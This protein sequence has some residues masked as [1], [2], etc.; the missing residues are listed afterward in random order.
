MFTSPNGERI[1]IMGNV[2]GSLD[3]Q[4]SFSEFVDHSQNCIVQQKVLP[5]SKPH[6]AAFLD[7]NGDC[8]SDLFFTSVDGSNKFHE[9][10]LRTEST[11]SKH[12]MY[13]LKFLKG[14]EK[15]SSQVTFTDF[16]RDGRVDF[17][18]SENGKVLVQRNQLPIPEVGGEDCIKPSIEQENTMF[19]VQQ[20]AL[21]SE[22]GMSLPTG[23]ASLYSSEGL[24]ATIR[25][26]DYNMDGYPDFLITWKNSSS[27]TP[28]AFLCESDGRILDNLAACNIISENV[29]LSTFFDLDEDGYF[30]YHCFDFI[31]S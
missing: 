13:C 24:P 31:K 2:N 8:L 9:I 6:S 4:V 19:Y 3:K 20:G 7:L 28:Q 14:V 11:T 5:F 23:V 30:N 1:V 15:D 18:Y 27:G 21:N 16:D 29:M 12:V 25:V 17:I 22:L 26:G 10:W